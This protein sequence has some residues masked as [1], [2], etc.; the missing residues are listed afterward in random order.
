M[1]IPPSMGVHPVFH[2]AL[3]QPEK[4]RPEEM[5]IDMAWEP[6]DPEI[7][8][9]DPVY[10]VEFILD[11]RGSPGN[12]EYLV[13]WKGFPREAAT[14]EPEKNLEGCKQLLREFRRNMARSRP[15]GGTVSTSRRKERSQSTA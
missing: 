8:A 6:V 11:Q 15:C 13:K 7:A 3:L 9:E 2:V 5:R 10:E 1:D 12:R 4:E 14:W